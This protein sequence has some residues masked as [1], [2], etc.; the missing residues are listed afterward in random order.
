VRTR[1][2]GGRETTVRKV[3]VARSALTPRKE[4]RVEFTA[5]SILLL[6]VL[7]AVLAV[8]VEKLRQ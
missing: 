8:L 4:D 2:T 7:L 1:T 3:S 5:F 6:V